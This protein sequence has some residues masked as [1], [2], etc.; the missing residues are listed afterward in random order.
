MEM[1]Q[2]NISL[3]KLMRSIANPKIEV[4]RDFKYIIPETGKDGK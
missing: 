2:I 1:G 4:I 3:P